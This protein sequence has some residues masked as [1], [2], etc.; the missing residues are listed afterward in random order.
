MLFFFFFKERLCFL[1]TY[2]LKK[3]GELK[4]V[5]RKRVNILDNNNM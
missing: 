5:L 2:S 3:I 4:K 1:I